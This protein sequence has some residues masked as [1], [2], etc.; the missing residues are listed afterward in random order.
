M[1]TTPTTLPPDVERAVEGW[2]DEPRQSAERLIQTYGSPDEVTSSFLIWHEKASPWKRTV[3]SRQQATH[4]FPSTHQD[5]VEQTIDYEVPVE[6][7]EDLARYDRSVLV[8]GTRGELSARCGGTSLNFL[9]INLAVELIE[10]RRSVEDA[11]RIYAQI[12]KRYHAGDED[13]LTQGFR[14]DLPTG[15]TGDPDEPVD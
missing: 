3:L 14:F 4:A 11:R 12:A 7:V 1:A 10:G 6:A 13:P 5:F 8:D 9:A 15:S 2:P